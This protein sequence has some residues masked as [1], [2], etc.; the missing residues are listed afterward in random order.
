MDTAKTDSD[1]QT[2]IDRILKHPEFEL[3]NI[4]NDPWELK[5]LATN[6]EYAE[7]IKT[8][9]AQLKADMDK[10]NDEFSTVDPK[11]EKKQRNSKLVKLNQKRVRKK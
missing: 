6:P 3:Y 7:T 8:M 2:K 4:K 11:A 10:M 5:N 9:H 1:A